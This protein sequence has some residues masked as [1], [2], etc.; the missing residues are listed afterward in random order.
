MTTISG[1]AGAIT[2][3]TNYYQNQ[4]PVSAGTGTTAG[5]TPLA[6]AMIGVVGTSSASSSLSSL[7]GTSTG[8]GATTLSMLLGLA[9]DGASMN[10]LFSSSAS[11]N[12]T[13]TTASLITALS[14]TA[15]GKP[16]ATANL[17]GFKNLLSEL[18]SP[19]GPAA[20]VQS[21]P[22]DSNA[23]NLQQQAV[24]SALAGA[25]SQSQRNLLSLLV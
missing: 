17:G 7:F 13:S 20:T 15:T 2:A 1:A 3:L 14:G 6:N 16:S 18:A 4:I 21:T 22:T 24:F 25:Y 19:N 23:A 11:G 10:G 5:Q 9:N 8:S 12:T